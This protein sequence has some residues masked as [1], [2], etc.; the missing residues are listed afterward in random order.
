MPRAISAILM[1]MLLGCHPK[2]APIVRPEAEVEQL[3]AE[4]IDA[5]QKGDDKKAASYIISPLISDQTPE[6]AQITRDLVLE[7]TKRIGVMIRELPSGANPKGCM[8]KGNFA[9]LLVEPKTPG[10]LEPIYLRQTP[11]SWKFLSG[12]AMFSNFDFQFDFV[13]SDSDFEDNEEINKWVA[14]QIGK[15]EPAGAGQP[16][17]K[18]A[19]KPPVKD[20]PSTPTSK[21][22][23]R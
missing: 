23:P 12:L 1:C 18:P 5:F 8:V 6:A 17:I 22:A 21:D 15:S 19:D 13:E 11:A 2:K 3:F 7:E 14:R 20:K 16:A 9:V 10:S 4:L